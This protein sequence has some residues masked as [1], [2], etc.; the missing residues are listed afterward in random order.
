[1]L[2]P[3]GTNINHYILQQ[4]LSSFLVSRKAIQ[5]LTNSAAP[6]PQNVASCGI[7]RV[8]IYTNKKHT[9]STTNVIE[10]LLLQNNFPSCNGNVA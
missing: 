3:C 2:Q 8:G 1:M 10:S 6:F 9:S 4:W 5:S 7:F